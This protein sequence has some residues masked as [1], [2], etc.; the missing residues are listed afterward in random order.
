[1]KFYRVQD[2]QG[3][4]PY[5]VHT[6]FTLM[7]HSRCPQHPGPYNDPGIQRGIRPEERCGFETLAE[8]Q[9][10]FTPRELAM[11]RKLGYT[12]VEVEGTLTAKGQ[13]QCLFIP[14]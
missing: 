7:R 10:W 14:N 8:L 12:V 1:M 4:G 2:A 6:F 9:T 13:Y 3:M 5:H 11:L